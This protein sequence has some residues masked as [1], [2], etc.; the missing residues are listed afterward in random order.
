MEPGPK[1]C[2]EGKGRRNFACPGYAPCLNEAASCRWGGFTCQGCPKRDVVRSDWRQE[3][4]F[5]QDGLSTL[6]AV[7]LGSN[8]K[9]LRAELRRG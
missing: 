5:D 1:Q 7:I 2:A 8:W 6:A 4:L 3:A 9:A